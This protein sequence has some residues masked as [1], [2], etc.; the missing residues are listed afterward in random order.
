MS[1]PGS[2]IPQHPHPAG[3][4]ACW[5]RRSL[6]RRAS[7]S[8]RPRHTVRG[9]DVDATTI[10]ELQALMDRHRLTSVQLTQ[11]Y[12]HRIK[13]LN[14]RA[15]RG[16]H[17]QPDGDSPTRAR[18]TRHGA[19]A[20][21]AR[22]WGSRSSS[23]T[24]STRPACRRPPGSW[25]LAGSTPADAFIVQQLQGGRRDRHRQGEPVRVGELPLDPVVQRLERHRRPDEHGVRPR[26]QPVRLELGI[27]RR[28]RPPISPWPPSGPR[29]MVRSS[30]RPARTRVVGIKPTLGLLSR[31]GIIPISADQDT[32]GPMTRNVT[33][34]AVLLGA[35]TGHRSRRPGDRRRRSCPPAPTTPRSSTKR[36][37]GRADRRLAGRDGTSTAIPIDPRRRRDHAGRDRR[38]S[39]AQGATVIEVTLSTRATTYGP[40]FVA[41]LCEFKTDIA[42]ICE[43]Y[44]GRGLP[45]EPRGR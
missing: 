14:P 42:P 20:T 21:T 39:K 10:P 25:A 22:C 23:R 43:T 33:D 9:I 24:T 31:A 44:T 5:R 26:P 13:K 8:S 16:H 29:P 30:A 36:A 3:A 41:L 7:R 40:E 6:P 45:E 35:L 2:T 34:A 19:R 37:R 17:G 4:A 12:L 1:Q 28:A 18:R 11:F 15:A 32:A 38:R 27:R